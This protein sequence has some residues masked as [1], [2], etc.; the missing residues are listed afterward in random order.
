M[1]IGHSYVVA[2]NRRL[3]H[4]MA[5]QSHG[6]WAV[7]T[8]APARLRGD[9]R[10]IELEPIAGEACTVVP[11]PVHLGRYPH[12]R[13]Y[14]GKLRSLLIQPWDLVHCWEEPYVLAAAQIA[15]QLRPTTKFVPATF[16][17]IAKRYPFP[18]AML[19]R[20]VMSRA[21]AWIAFGQT[22]Y[23]T[24]RERPGYASKPARVLNP[25]VDTES[26]HPDPIARQQMR[27][28]LGWKP[29]DCVVGFT[30]RFVEEKGIRTL[31]E[32]FVQSKGGWNLMFVGGGALA[33]PIE[34]PMLM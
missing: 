10:D 13:I 1:T 26:F 5:R 12:L 8:A 7:T 6:E 24:Q 15:R 25:G 30:G 9:L 3:A 20:R 18:V 22:A 23:D 27:N 11:L 29:A 34:S 17:N 31:L 16:Q 4:E 14:G 28:I 19:E 2:Q 32:A 21:D 33:P